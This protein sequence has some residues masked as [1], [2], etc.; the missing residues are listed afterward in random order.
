V[1]LLLSRP[2]PSG[3]ET[4]PAEYPKGEGEAHP[5]GAKPLPILGVLPRVRLEKVLGAILKCMIIYDKGYSLSDSS[6]SNPSRRI[7]E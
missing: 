7:S 6:G 1:V 3:R 4:V 5:K 2:F